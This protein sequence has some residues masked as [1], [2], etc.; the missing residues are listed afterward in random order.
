[1]WHHSPHAQETR[2][3]TVAASKAS[4]IIEVDVAISACGQRERTHVQSQTGCGA[5]GSFG[6]WWSV[7]AGG[8]TVF[9]PSKITTFTSV[10]KL[11]RFILERKE[12]EQG[13]QRALNHTQT[14][15]DQNPTK[16][17]PRRERDIEYGLDGN[18]HLCPI[19]LRGS[20]S[21]VGKRGGKHE[22][23]R[24][25][26]PLNKGREDQQTQT[27]V[28]VCHEHVG[29]NRYEARNDGDDKHG[30]A[31]DAVRADAE[32]REREQRRDMAAEGEGHGPARGQGL[33]GGGWG[34]ESRRRGVCLR[35]NFGKFLRPGSLDPSSSPLSSSQRR[36]T[37]HTPTHLHLRQ[38][39]AFSKV[40]QPQGAVRQP[41]QRPIR[42]VTVVREPARADLEKQELLRGDHSDRMGEDME[43]EGDEDPEGG[44]SVLGL[45]GR[46]WEEGVRGGG[47]WQRA[48][49][50]EE[51]GFL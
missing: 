25:Q 15:P 20:I 27:D 8:S 38:S 16:I 17:R 34:M 5:E 19:E 18:K 30:L 12:R 43:E 35:R 40:G 47:V 24:A 41:C 26:A 11:N 1:M 10:S 2:A 13:L 23:V 6:G 29:E 49:V 37:Q 28:R 46:G 42:L 9:G 4:K 39:P 36:T 44:G 33:R 14:H 45:T 48:R 22:H 21:H 50:R 7:V 32:E 3:H 31:A 51:R